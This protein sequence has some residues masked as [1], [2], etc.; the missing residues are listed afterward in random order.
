MD[1]KTSVQK[2][3]EKQDLQCLPKI[4]INYKGKGGNFMEE[5]PSRD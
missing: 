5:K 1:A 3:E 4:F 2:F